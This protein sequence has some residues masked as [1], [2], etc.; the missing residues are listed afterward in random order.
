MNTASLALIWMTKRLPLPQKETKAGKQDM[1]ERAVSSQKETG[2]ACSVTCN[3]ILKQLN[4][5]IVDITN[6]T[7]YC[8]H[9]NNLLP[10]A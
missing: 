7:S 1:E 10:L 4:N 5:D 8:G 6:I 9:C 3:S 2:F